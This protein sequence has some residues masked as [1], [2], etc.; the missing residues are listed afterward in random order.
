MTGGHDEGVHA[1]AG[2]LAHAVVVQDL[3]SPACAAQFIVLALDV[4]D[5]VMEPE[6]DL[7][8]ARVPGLVRHGF[9]M[10]QAFAQMLQRV[11]VALRLGV[12]GQNGLLQALGRR[13]VKRLPGSPPGAL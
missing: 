10:R 3:D 2:G 7:H 9:E 6:R 5:G 1:P 11:I 13:G 8:F 4:V 12:G